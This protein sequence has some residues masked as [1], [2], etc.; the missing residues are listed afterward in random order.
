MEEPAF[1][2]S[3]R[4]GCA[5]N[6]L[7]AGQNWSVKVSVVSSVSVAKVAA[8]VQFRGTDPVPANNYY[9]VTMQ[10]SSKVVSSGGQAPISQPP[11]L[12]PNMVILKPDSDTNGQ[13]SDQP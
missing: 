2:N 5:L 12:M 11:L 7:P 4:L 3:T 9:I 10:K 8:L 6:T 1:A 13:V